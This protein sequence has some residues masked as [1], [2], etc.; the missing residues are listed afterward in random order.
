MVNANLGQEK[1]QDI[2][3]SITPAQFARWLEE[4]AEGALRLRAVFWRFDAEKLYTTMQINPRMK[5]NL[6][7]MRS[8][9]ETMI[10]RI[11]DVRENI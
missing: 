10:E 6:E 5:E 4:W 8:Y 2:A 9:L 3:D 11:D 1:K 7:F